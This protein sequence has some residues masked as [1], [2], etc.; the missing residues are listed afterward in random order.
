LFHGIHIVAGYFLA[1]GARMGIAFGLG[2]SFI[3]VVFAFSPSGLQYF[4]TASFFGVRIYFAIVIFL[5]ITARKELETLRTMNWRPWM[6]YS[7]K[8]HHHHGL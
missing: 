5:I 3:E 2:I 8:K 6:P 4:Y 1:K 7:N